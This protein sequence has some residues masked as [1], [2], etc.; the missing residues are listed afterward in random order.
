LVEEIGTGEVITVTVGKEEAIRTIRAALAIGAHRGIL[1]K[2]NE[3]FLDGSITALALKKAIEAD[4]KP[5]LIFT[6]RVSVDSEGFQVPYRLAMALEMPVISDVIDFKVVDGK[7]IAE[8]EIE[9]GSK[10]VIELEMPCVVA[11]TKGM[12]EVRS[13]TLPSIMRAKK[14]E[15]KRLD[16]G[17]I[18]VDN[19][20]RKMQLIELQPVPER[21]KADLIMLDGGPQEMAQQLV[22]L[23][24]KEKILDF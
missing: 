18:G 19:S 17:E 3:Q 15:V 21:G 2:T 8:R 10:E 4:G 6:G 12:N 23:L 5:D 14:K 13:P 22:D 11:V 16:I 24:R 9:G 20:S 1:V 7:A